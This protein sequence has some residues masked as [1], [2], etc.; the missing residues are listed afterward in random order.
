[1]SLKT[2][3]RTA[4]I[5]LLVLALGT[6][7]SFPLTAE[8]TGGWLTPIL[9]F[10]FARNPSDIAFLQGE[11]GVPL[12]AAMHAGHRW[13]AFFPLAYGTLLTIFARRAGAIWAGFGVLSILFD[14]TENRA[15]ESILYT[16]DADQQV[17]TFHSLMIA[18]SAKWM[19]IAVASGAIAWVAKDRWTQR[20]GSLLALLVILTV[21]FA[22]P[23]V[24]EPMAVCL[25]AWFS[26][27]VYKSWSPSDALTEWG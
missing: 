16:L 21:V 24:A 1:M 5:A 27:L 17:G 15:L 6:F 23:Y 2:A 14:W 8:L 19:C 18:T 12:R 11:P 26:T 3:A 9:A 7:A 10:E 13:D 20:L 25:I 4:S 22:H